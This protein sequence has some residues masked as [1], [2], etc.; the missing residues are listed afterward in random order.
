MRR[1]IQA[2]KGDPLFGYVDLPNIW[3]SRIAELTEKL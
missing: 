3:R 1:C 2:F